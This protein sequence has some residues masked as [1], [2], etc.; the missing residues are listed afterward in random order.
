MEC[1]R[2]ELKE[3]LCRMEQRCEVCCLSSVGC[4]PA[5]F[6]TKIY[7]TNETNFRKILKEDGNLPKNRFEEVETFCSGGKCV[8]L[9][10][11]V[12]RENE[13]CFFR[14]RMGICTNGTCDF[15]FSYKQVEPT[16]VGG[17]FLETSS[18]PTADLSIYLGLYL[19]IKM[20][21]I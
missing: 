10:F 8:K 5:R 9:G 4:V 2:I 3:C 13:F 14:G 18:G 12:F 16:V 7:L 17:E 15:P 6:A 11:K 21:L 20:Y 1:A 19:F